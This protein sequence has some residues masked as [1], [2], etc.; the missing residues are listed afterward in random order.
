[1][2]QLAAIDL[3]FLLLENQIRP[4]HM[5]SCL[6]FEPPAGKEKAF[7][8]RLLK[9]FRAA[10]PGKPFNQKLKWLEGGVARWEPAQPDPPLPCAAC[11]HSSARDKGAA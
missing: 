9:A 6:V 1:M 11:C 4:M 8:L 5:S 10:E 2:T 7:V 3:V